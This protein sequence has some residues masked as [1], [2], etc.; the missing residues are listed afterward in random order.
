MSGSIGKH[1]TTPARSRYAEDGCRLLHG[2]MR[3]NHSM[4]PVEVAL[5]DK[6]VDE[7]IRFSY[8]STRQSISDSAEALREILEDQP[9][10]SRFCFV[11]HSMGNIVVRHL[12][13][14]LQRD[15]DPK[16]ILSRCIGMAMLGP[17]NQGA[18]I[19]RNLAPTG[20]F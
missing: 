17:P 3:T 8:A 1:K 5:E 18:S 4:K 14:D 12:I 2:L 13:G 10:N 19:A 9:S 6:L 16:A 20:H 15:G 7:T 11:G